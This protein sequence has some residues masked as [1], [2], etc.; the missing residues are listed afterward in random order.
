MNAMVQCL[1][2]TVI[3]RTE[4]KDASSAVASVADSGPGI[5]SEKPSEVFDPFLTTKKQDMGIGLSIAR[6]LALS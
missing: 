4:M 3:G 5:P 2:R 1:G 6:T